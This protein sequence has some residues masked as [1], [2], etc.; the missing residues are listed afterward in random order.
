MC[1]CVLCVFS[2]FLPGGGEDKGRLW[3]WEQEGEATI[4]Q[5][6]RVL[7]KHHRRRLRATQS[8][9]SRRLCASSPS[10]SP[11]SPTLL[12]T[13][14]HMPRDR[15][16]CLPAA[17][18]M[19]HQIP[20][21]VLPLSLWTSS[22]PFLYSCPPVSACHLA[23]LTQG[24]VTHSD[25]HSPAPETLINS[26]AAMAMA[27]SKRGHLSQQPPLPSSS[28]TRCVK[29]FASCVMTN[30]SAHVEGKQISKH[31][32]GLLKCSYN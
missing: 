26:A 11:A 4:S 12:H 3:R 27:S 10:R 1:V 18:D 21:R 9:E 25:S 13:H 19:C 2:L 15:A 28:A 22:P 14:M 29:P 23:G 31:S 20:T 5:N 30:A 8:K 32:P 7:D 17:P 16:S 6:R 24:D